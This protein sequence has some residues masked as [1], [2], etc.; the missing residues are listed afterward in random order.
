MHYDVIVVGAGAA[1]AVAAT[2]ISEDPARSVLLLEA[3]PHYPTA[4]QTPADLLNGND[5]SCF[6]HDWG[7]EATANIAGRVVPLPAGRVVGGSSAVNTA[8]AFFDALGLAAFTVIG[9]VVAVESRSNPLWLWGPLL[10]ALTGAGGG[11]IR[12][13]DLV[14]VVPATVEAPDIPV[15]HTRDHFFQL[16]IGAKEMFTCVGPALGL[17]VLIFAVERLSHTAAQQ[18]VLVFGQ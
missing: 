4:S 8:I 2:R 9:V 14:R 1:G 18:A 3:G 13:V 12:R 16:R 10:A 15:G 6:A 7:Y 5:N 17:V 11:I